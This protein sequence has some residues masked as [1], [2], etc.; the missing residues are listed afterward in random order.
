MINVHSWIIESKTIRQEH[1]RLDESCIERGGESYQHRG[2]LAEYLN[3][4]IPDGHKIH[5]CHACNNGRCSNPRH[6]YW[7]TAIENA[8]D[9]VLC[10]A[11]KSRKGLPG[12]PQT[13]ETKRKI[14]LANKNKPPNNP[15]GI[16]GGGSL[17]KTYK[18]SYSQICITDGVNNTR[19]RST[20]EIPNGWRRGRILRN[21]RIGKTSVSETENSR[22]EP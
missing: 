7:G 5:L 11:R 12:H 10:G 14:S 1:L 17:G 3:T 8:I 6:L 21:S 22:F 9:A 13:E 2:V 4:T 20:L 19:I 16:N 18:R 15:N